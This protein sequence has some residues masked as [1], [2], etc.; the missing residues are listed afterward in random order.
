[1]RQN[2]DS[3]L[4]VLEAFIHDP[5]LQW[6][7]LENKKSVFAQPDSAKLT[8]QAAGAAGQAPPAAGTAQ[9]QA[10]RMQPQQQQQSQQS[11]AGGAGRPQA[12]RTPQLGSQQRPPQ[13]TATGAGVN[14]AAVGG[15]GG[16]MTSGAVGRQTGAMGTG[17]PSGS[18]RLGA[19][20]QTPASAHSRNAPRVFTNPA[21]PASPSLRDYHKVNPWRHHLCNGPWLGCYETAKTMRRQTESG[22]II[23]ERKGLQAFIFSAKL[24]PENDGTEDSPGPLLQCCTALTTITSPPP[25]TLTNM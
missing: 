18:S 7:L 11:A 4:A 10:T 16:G 3:L 12:S 13:T 25:T 1:M 6:V 17:A 8:N 23:G 5:L 14:T 21:Y 15:G 22:S 9:T 2:R 24:I 19:Y 20:G